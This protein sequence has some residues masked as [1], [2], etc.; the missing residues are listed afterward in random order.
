MA[1]RDEVGIGS[2][3]GSVLCDN[4]VPIRNQQDLE[5]VMANIKKYEERFWEDMGHPLCQKKWNDSVLGLRKKVSVYLRP[6][7][8]KERARARRTG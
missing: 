5:L 2:G 6:I 4:E 1:R 8:V 3:L 7:V